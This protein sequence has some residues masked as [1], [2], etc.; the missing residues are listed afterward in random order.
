MTC[1]PDTKSLIISFKIKRNDNI[2]IV[3]IIGKTKTINDILI[4]QIIS[5]F[6]VYGINN[7]THKVLFI[8]F[9]AK[10]TFR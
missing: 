1:S 8:H 9:V 4:E 5:Q 3:K 10:E 7:G 6:I 2:L